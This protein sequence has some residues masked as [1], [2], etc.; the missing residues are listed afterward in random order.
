MYVAA[1][2]VSAFRNRVGRKTRGPATAQPS[3]PTNLTTLSMGGPRE[4]VPPHQFLPSYVVLDQ[5]FNPGRW[6][7]GP[8][9]KIAVNF[10]VGR[11]HLYP[12]IFRDWIYGV[13]RAYAIAIDIAE[14]HSAIP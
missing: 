14:Y 11:A 7:D 6:V 2:S 3:H 9:E 5:V 8:V 13:Y 4:D 12:Q 1:S 10:W